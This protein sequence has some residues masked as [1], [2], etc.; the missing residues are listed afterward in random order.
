MRGEIIFYNKYKGYGFI[1][2]DNLAHHIYFNKNS[3]TGKGNFS[4]G[5]RVR[6]TLA[7]AKLGSKAVNITIDKYFAN[8]TIISRITSIILTGSIFTFLVWYLL[9]HI[10]YP[11]IF[12]QFY[13]TGT[14]KN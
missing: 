12:Y 3:I 10:F 9:Q 7:R 13:F 2:P 14:I 11:L 1:K 4:S 5:T 8:I 6:F